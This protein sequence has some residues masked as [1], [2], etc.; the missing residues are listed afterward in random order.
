MAA[1]KGRL[2]EIVN[3]SGIPFQLRI[4]LEIRASRDQHPWD[5][6]GHEVPWQDPLTSLSGFADLV[7]ENG[8]MR[9][10]V[11][12]KRPDHQTPYLFLA[13]HARTGVEN[14]ERLVA[15]WT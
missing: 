11:E 9:V 10:V 4:E 8:N 5:V 13:P 12:C 1:E 2:L 6:A 7:L 3:A 15:C 14:T